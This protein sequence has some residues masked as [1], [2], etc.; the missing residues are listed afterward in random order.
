MQLT[1]SC[2]EEPEKANVKVRKSK[3]Q[4]DKKRRNVGK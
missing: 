4:R 1:E 3:A 2:R